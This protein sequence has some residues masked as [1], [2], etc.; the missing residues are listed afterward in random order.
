MLFLRLRQHLP[1]E[2]AALAAMQTFSGFGAA[3]SARRIPKDD[4]SASTRYVVLVPASRRPTSIIKQ[5]A[6]QAPHSEWTLIDMDAEG[7]ETEVMPEAG[8]T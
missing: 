5:L 1:N 8:A 2:R 7:F 4:G 3:V 6:A